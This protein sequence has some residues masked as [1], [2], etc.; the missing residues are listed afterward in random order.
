[1]NKIKKIIIAVIAVAGMSTTI[2]AQEFPIYNQYHFHGYLM[3]PALAGAA[4]CAHFMLTHKQQWIGV[5]DAPMTSILSFQTRTEKRLGIGAYLFVD[6][7]GYS[8]QQ[9]G[10]FSLAYHIPMSLGNRYSKH[11]TLDRQLSFGV[12]GKVYHYD[13][14]QEVLDEAVVKGEIV[15][16]KEGFLPNANFGMFY[17]SYGFF[18]GLSITNLIPVKI[19]IF[20]ENEPLRPLTAFYQIGYAIDAQ[21]NVQLEPSAVFHIDGNARKQLDV[22]FRVLQHLDRDDISWWAGVTAKQNFD[23]EYKALVLLPNFT[24]RLGKFRIG[25]AVNLDLNKLFSSNYGSHELMLGY[26]FCSTKQFCR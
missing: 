20:G 1:M 6:K 3:N 19:D 14:A 23:S 11:T 16:K 9:G 21:R 2:Q 17:E 5:K 18:T 12:S 10:Q 26:S 24:I 8:Y 7:N 25:Y 22:S 4:E 13:F 15:Q